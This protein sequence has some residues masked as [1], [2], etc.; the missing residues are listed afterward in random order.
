MGEAILV[1]G[2]MGAVEQKIYRWKEYQANGTNVYYWNR[3]NA[4]ST[5][6]YIWNQFNTVTQYT[7]NKWGLNTS[8][9]WNKYS[10]KKEAVTQSV[11]LGSP[12]ESNHTRLWTDKPYTKYTTSSGRDTPR[13]WFSNGGWSVNLSKSSVGKAI[14]GWIP[15][16]GTANGSEIICIYSAWVTKCV[17]LTDDEDGRMCNVEITGALTAVMKYS[18]E[19]LVG[20]VTSTNVNAYPNGGVHADDGWYYGSRTT[21]YSKGTYVGIVQS[22]DPNDY[23][24]G[25]WS[26]SNW[27]DGR[28]EG[29]IKGSTSY[30][31]I[32]STNSGAYPP[33][34]ASGSYWYESAG[35]QISW[36]QGSISYPQVSST[37][38]GAYPSNDH[39]DDYWYTYDRVEIVYSQGECVGDRLSTDRNRWPDNG[40]A[41]GYWYIFNGEA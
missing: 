9:K 24:N 41:N 14:T 33:S 11:S 10:T 15:I 18:G 26:G 4:I 39:Q 30:G 32:S 1:G 28:S 5:T 27:Y 8:Y 6:E 31:Q 2:R 12:I 25:S 34:G 16:N 21:I 29:L 20:T 19:N 13:L 37:N 22:T 17:S 40:Y 38:S 36:S 7:W 23:P 3:W 35:S